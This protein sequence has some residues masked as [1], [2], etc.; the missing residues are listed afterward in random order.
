MRIWV[1]SLALLSGLR[2]WCCNNHRCSSDPVLP[3]LWY[4][5]EAATLVRPLAQELPHDA[6]VAV[7]RG[8]IRKKERKKE[9]KQKKGDTSFCLTHWE[10]S[11]SFSFFLSFFK[12]CTHGIWKFPGQGLKPSSSCTYATTV[13]TS[14]PLTHCTRPGTEP[15]P[16]QQ[17]EQLILDS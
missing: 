16:L 13:I 6:R 11:L 9:R 12:G 17:P 3:Q 5:P 10:Y 1:W 4:R 7:K 15:A 8:K 2:I 14:D